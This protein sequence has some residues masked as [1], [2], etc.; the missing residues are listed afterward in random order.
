MDACN[1]KY[2]YKNCLKTCKQTEK[3]RHPSTEML[4]TIQS[5][6]LEIF[7]PQRKQK[8]DPSPQKSIILSVFSLFS[9]FWVKN[10]NK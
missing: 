5:M 9:A 2:K 8:S 7:K 6:F 4:V 1:F 3:S 10:L